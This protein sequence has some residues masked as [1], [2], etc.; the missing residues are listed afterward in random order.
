MQK[1]YSFFKCEWFLILFKET[2][3]FQMNFLN[4][5]IQTANINVV[6]RKYKTMNLFTIITTMN[7]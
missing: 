5:T 4:A 6:T 2:V 1:L 7:L 3:M